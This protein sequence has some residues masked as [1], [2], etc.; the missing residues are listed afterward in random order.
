MLKLKILR[1]LKQGHFSMRELCK[2][3]EISPTTLQ[4]RRF[5]L[6]MEG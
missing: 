6:E 5:R 1:L 3:Y 2:Q 4:R